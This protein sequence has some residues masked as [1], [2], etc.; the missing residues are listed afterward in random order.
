MFG[1]ATCILLTSMS[2][3]EPVFVGLGLNWYT[4]KAIYWLIAPAG[5]LGYAFGFRLLS[6]RF[7]R[8]YAVIFTAEIALRSMR[9]ILSSEGARHGTLTTVLCLGMFALVCVALL[10]Y[11][12]LLRGGN[13]SFEDDQATLRKVF[14]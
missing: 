4:A 5:L 14:D 11:A 13:S 7:W 12:N 6:V 1:L 2:L 9:L 10:R 8:V 3:I